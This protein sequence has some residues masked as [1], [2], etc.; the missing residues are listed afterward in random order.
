MRRGGGTLLRGR[1]GG[2]AAGEAHGSIG[3]A[4]GGQEWAGDG[5]KRAA[6]LGPGEGEWGG[7]VESR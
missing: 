6:V 2:E 5:E 3:E 7:T 4:R 1:W